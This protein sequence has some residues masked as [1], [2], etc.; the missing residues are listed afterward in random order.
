MVNDDKCSATQL[1]EITKGDADAR[2]IQAVR[3][4]C[5]HAIATLSDIVLV[6]LLKETLVYVILSRQR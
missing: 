2:S 6:L 3:T 4:R 1:A 5:L